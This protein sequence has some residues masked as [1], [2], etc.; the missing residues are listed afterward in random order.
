MPSLSRVKRLTFSA[1]TRTYALATSESKFN[2]NQSGA[3][4]VY[5]SF[6]FVE[7][8]NNYVVFPESNTVGLGDGYKNKNL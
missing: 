5:W 2:A 4:D 6:H 7:C 3:G 1:Y 8:E